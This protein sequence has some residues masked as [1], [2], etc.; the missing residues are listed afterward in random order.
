MSWV[1]WDSL[2]LFCKLDGLAKHRQS[3][4]QIALEEEIGERDAALGAGHRE[5]LLLVEFID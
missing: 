3:S 1:G 5:G 4:C 2:Q